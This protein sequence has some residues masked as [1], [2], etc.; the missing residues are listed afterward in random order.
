MTKTNLINPF[1][2]IKYFLLSKSKKKLYLKSFEL[3]YSQ[4]AIEL[5][6]YKRLLQSS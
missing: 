5:Q 6:K 4:Q 3:A 2:N 1:F